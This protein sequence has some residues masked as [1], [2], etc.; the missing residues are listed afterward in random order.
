MEANSGA[1]N[2]AKVF[3]EKIIIKKSNDYTKVCQQILGASVCQVHSLKL[4]IVIKV[5]WSSEVKANIQ[6]QI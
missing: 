6:K 3:E 5:F 4:S 2:I 1:F